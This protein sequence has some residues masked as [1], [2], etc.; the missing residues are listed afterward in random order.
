MTRASERIHPIRAHRKAKKM[1][2]IQ[3]AA[4]LNIPQNSLS[5]Y[6]LG[7]FPGREVLRKLHK[8]G[9]DIVAVILWCPSANLQIRG[10]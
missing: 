9:V 7:K 6:E 4:M 1:T 3:Y 5:G 8:V 10:E 2:Q